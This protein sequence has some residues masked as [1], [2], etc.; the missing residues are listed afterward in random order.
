[1]K[2][3]IEFL[4]GISHKIN[5]ILQ[6]DN[7]AVEVMPDYLRE[8]VKRY[9]LAGGKKLRP[10][11]LAASCGILGGK[12]E[13][14]LE[15]ATAVEIWH[16]W[17]L[18]HDDIID[19]DTFRR[20][21]PTAHCRLAEVAATKFDLSKADAFKYGEN[22]AI[23]CGDLQINWAYNLII[24]GQQKSKISADLTLDIIRKIQQFGAIKLISGEAVDVELAVKKLE[25]ITPAEV[26]KMIDGK[27]SALFQ[28]SCEIGGALALGTFDDFRIQLLSDFAQALGRAFQL[29]DD[30]LGIFGDVNKFGKNIGSDLREGKPTILLL[31]T[32]QSASCEEKAFILGCIG[33]KDLQLSQIEEVK[34]I[35]ISSDAYEFVNNEVQYYLQR[36]KEYLNELPENN[37]NDILHEL[38][39]YLVNRNK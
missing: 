1:M 17:T 36:A 18:V 30:L 37:Y 6:S 7:F 33:E 3:C 29:Q 4:D 39:E 31:K 38:L 26:M 9:P 21:Q 25:N 8:E 12:P 27:T 24:K 28:C 13:K 15:F 14:F 20:N 19:C 2:K 11:L 23:L 22:M 32:L 16:N 34:R 10:A 35:M 5:N